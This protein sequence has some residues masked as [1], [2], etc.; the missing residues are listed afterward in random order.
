MLP[1]ERLN[2]I[3]KII[4]E[5][6]QSDVVTLSQLL[7]VTE[8]TIRRDLEKLE[9]EG[10]ITRTH[11]GA[12]LNESTQPVT[13]LF[14]TS[15][16]D[17]SLYTPISTVAA[18]F[19]NHNDVIFLG[20]GITSR[21][22][23][24]SLS[25]KQNLLV[26][27]TDLMVAHDCA[28]YSPLVKVFLSGGELNPSTLQLSGRITTNNLNAFYFDVAF[29]DIDGISLERGYSVSSLEKAYLIQDITKISKQTFAV[30]DYTKFSTDSAATVGPINFFQSVISNER[31]AKEYKEYYFNNNIKF[32]ATFNAYRG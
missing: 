7:N 19:I 24:R 23:I 29:F 27:T 13:S 2:K 12:I 32:F 1:M 31:T 16:V 25:D 9:N 18:H 20:P 11:G 8:A 22:I 10:F 5:N 6:K 28:V 26:V 3:K 4:T 17:Y 14:D 21:Y 30:C 15:N